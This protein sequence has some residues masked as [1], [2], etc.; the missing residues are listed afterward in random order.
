MCG[1]CK[2]IVRPS[3]DYIFSGS[4]SN[5]IRQNTLYYIRRED[6]GKKKKRRRVLAQG[7]SRKFAA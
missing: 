6:K 4:K 3:K 7:E 1:E 5:V 2:P